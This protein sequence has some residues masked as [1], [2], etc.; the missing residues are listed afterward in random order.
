M[1]NFLFA[2]NLSKLLLRVRIFQLECMRTETKKLGLG[3]GLD[4]GLKAKT[5]KHK[6]ITSGLETR[7]PIGLKGMCFGFITHLI[8][9]YGYM[10][11]EYQI[12]NLISN[13]I[14]QKR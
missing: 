13:L 8:W 7:K 10:N 4:F 12:S 1:K 2:L 5:Y 9:V 14:S 11:F 6:S 3:L